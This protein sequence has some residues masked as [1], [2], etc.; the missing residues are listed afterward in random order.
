MGDLEA[1]DACGDRSALD[2]LRLGDRDGSD[3]RD[4]CSEDDVD[5]SVTAHKDG[6]DDDDGGS[7]DDDDGDSIVDD[8]SEPDSDDDTDGDDQAEAAGGVL[9]WTK[10]SSTQGRP[11]KSPVRIATRVCYQRGVEIGVRGWPG[12]PVRCGAAGAHRGASRVCRWAHLAQSGT[13]CGRGECT[14]WPVGRRASSQEETGNKLGRCR[15]TGCCASVQVRGQHGTRFHGDAVHASVL[16]T[17]RD[18]PPRRRP[19]AEAC[20]GAWGATCRRCRAALVCGVA[21]AF[22]VVV[23]HGC[24]VGQHRALNV[25]RAGRDV[26]GRRALG[27]HHRGAPVVRRGRQLGGAEATTVVSAQLYRK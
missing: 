24:R 22:T 15:A 2:K 3:C 19:V 6:I 11:L 17:G 8:S 18:A 1:A 10:T 26:Q 13:A 16:I 7:V 4:L 9:D 23:R 25:R 21:V 14:G 20:A 12:R 5:G 27:L